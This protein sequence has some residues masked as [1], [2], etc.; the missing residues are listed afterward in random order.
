MLDYND[1]YFT[2]DDEVKT[3]YKKPAG[4]TEITKILWVGGTFDRYF[5]RYNLEFMGGIK[6]WLDVDNIA[7]P[8]NAIW[9]DRAFWLWDIDK[10]FVAGKFN[11]KCGPTNTETCKNIA[12]LY[13]RGG[14][15]GWHSLV[16]NENAQ[17][18]PNGE[19]NTI[20]KV[21]DKMYMAGS[22]V[23]D[24]YRYLGIIDTAKKSMDS[25]EHVQKYIT[26][27][28]V[29]I[30]VC[31]TEESTL[32]CKEGSIFAAGQNGLLGFHDMGESVSG[33]WTLF[34]NGTRRTV[35]G[36]LVQGEIRSVA[37]AYSLLLF[38]LLLFFFFKNQKTNE[39][40]FVF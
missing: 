4:L 9:F 17:Y 5:K 34:G 28:L 32:G 22:F 1:R 25:V 36:T 12:Y 19:V 21:G 8:V 13:Y 18:L 38:F 3:V 15:R 33:K 20:Y 30:S 24:N 27:P 37:Y 29:D 10:I 16:S 35:N 14:N 2:D 7:G 11:R 23:N 31:S 40:N 39:L 6:G 26:E